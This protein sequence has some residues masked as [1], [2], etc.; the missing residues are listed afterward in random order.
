MAQIQMIVLE[1]DSKIT[2]EIEIKMS[3]ILPFKD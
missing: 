2:W 3:K 1:N